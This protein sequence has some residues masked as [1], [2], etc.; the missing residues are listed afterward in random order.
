MPCKSPYYYA[1]I[2]ICLKE[3]D[4]YYYITT[5]EKLYV[6]SCTKDQ[7]NHPGKKVGVGVYC[8]PTIKTAEGYAGISEVNGKSYKTVLMVRVN[9][10]SIRYSE[11]ERD[12]WV[13]DS[14]QIRPYRML[15]K[16]C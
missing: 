7:Y 11:E 16:E 9:P 2:K 12:Y 4:E 15:L 10:I 13:L 6:H 5:S 3:C 14:D 8:T 1:D